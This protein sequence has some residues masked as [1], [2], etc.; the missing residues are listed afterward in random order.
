MHKANLI[1]IL[2]LLVLAGCAA[3]RGPYTTS[4]DKTAKGAAIGAAVGALFS[5]ADGK[6]EADEILARAAI[7]AVVGGGIGAYMDAQEEKIARIPGTRVER[8]GADTL[9]VHFDSD[10]LF[11][12]DSSSLTA[13]SKETLQQTASVLADFPKTAII[14]QGHTDSSGSESHNQLLSERR[15]KA[16]LNYMVSRGVDP[17]RLHSLGYGESDPIASNDTALGRSKNRRVAIMLR[18]KAK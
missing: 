6:K 1:L 14:V 15:A 10:V 2:G 16:V 13:A 8:I 7:G 9:L 4:R 11:A 3:Q 5:V 17:M 18:A 12:V